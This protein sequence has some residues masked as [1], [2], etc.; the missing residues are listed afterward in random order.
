MKKMMV[1]AAGLLIASAALAAVPTP[2][3]FVGKAGQSDTFELD[4]ARLMVQSKN[5]GVRTFAVHMIADHEKSTKMVEAAARAD[6]VALKAPELTV[7]QRAD[8][9]ALKAVPAGKTK[10][11]LYIKQQKAAHADA[12][13]LMKEYSA[14]GSARHLK[15]TAAKIVP[16]V[17]QH[18]AMLSKL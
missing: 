2:A 9:T 1:A 10:D 12:L 14:A 5:P 18:Q 4:S 17:E 8:I 6:N 11:D 7:G 15:A 16:V 3:D 13:A